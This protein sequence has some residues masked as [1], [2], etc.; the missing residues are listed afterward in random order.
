MNF[1]L[2]SLIYNK[3]KSFFLKGFITKQREQDEY[4]LLPSS[5]TASNEVS[6]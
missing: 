6:K 1:E 4:A 5:L 3:K 2:E